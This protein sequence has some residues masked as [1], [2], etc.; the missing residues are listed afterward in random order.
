MI[1]Q[2]KTWK[3][4]YKKLPNQ[5]VFEMQ[6]TAKTEDDARRLSLMG[7]GLANRKNLEVEEVSIV[8]CEEI[9]D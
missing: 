5:R 3:V 4:K 8:S 7:V 1:M 9:K 2:D 6:T